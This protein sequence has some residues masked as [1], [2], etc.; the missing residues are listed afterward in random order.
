[1]Q[2]ALESNAKPPPPPVL[3][4]SWYSPARRYAQCDSMGLVAPTVEIK[5]FRVIDT[6]LCQIGV[7]LEDSFYI[8]EPGNEIYLTEKVGR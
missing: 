4:P 1:M 7:R 6:S 3:T 2:S 5:M 8:D